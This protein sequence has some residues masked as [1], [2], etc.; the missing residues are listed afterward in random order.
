MLNI[1]GKHKLILA[2]HG[3]SLT[4]AAAEFHATKSTTHEILKNKV[5]IQTF[6]W[7]IRDGD[8]IKERWTHISTFFV[9][10]YG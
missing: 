10:K 2:K 4:G 9:C 8:C 5:K 3:R 7:Q 1:E 6:L